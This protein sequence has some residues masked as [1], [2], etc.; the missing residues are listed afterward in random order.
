MK[1]IEVVAA[2]LRYKNKI[3]CLQR[4]YNKLEY[5]SGKFEFT[6]GKLKKVSQRKKH[7]NAN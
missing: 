5:I 4:A 2:I 3:L 7:L 6:G 1:K